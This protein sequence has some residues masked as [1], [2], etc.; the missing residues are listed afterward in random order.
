MIMQVPTRKIVPADSGA[1][2]TGIGTIVDSNTSSPTFM[3]VRWRPVKCTQ[4]ALRQV[5]SPA[6][7]NLLLHMRRPQ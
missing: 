3:N 2:I 7:C 1:G 5:V 6:H 4:P